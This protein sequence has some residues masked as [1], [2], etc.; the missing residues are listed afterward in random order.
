LAEIVSFTAA[1][2]A[3]SRRLMERLSFVRDATGDFDHP[4]IPEGHELR[5]HVLYRITPE[6]LPV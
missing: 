1:S 2:N 6:L 3:R 4:L 5:R